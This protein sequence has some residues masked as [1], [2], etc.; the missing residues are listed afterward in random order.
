MDGEGQRYYPRRELAG[1]LLGFVSPDGRGRD[2]L[3]LSLNKELEGHIEHLRGLRD[4]SGRLLF[5]D[6]I[7]DDQA[8]AG[9]NVYLTIDQGIQYVAEREL[10]LAARTFEA[11][12]GSVIVVNPYSGEILAMASWPGYNPNDYRYSDPGERRDRGLTD[13]FEPGSTMKIF[14]LA[15][16]LAGGV[17]SS[18]QKLYCEKGVMPAATMHSRVPREFQ[19]T[20]VSPEDA[21]P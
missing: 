15:A 2:G 11:S 9:H 1:P 4:R 21:L 20:V 16:G 10:A 5:A 3:E 12:G 14:D 8:L 7:Q 19:P 18:T 6:G 17:I 13:V